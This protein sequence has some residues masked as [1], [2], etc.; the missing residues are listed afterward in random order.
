VSAE[1][2]IDAVRKRVRTIPANRRHVGVV[3]GLEIEVVEVSAV[4]DALA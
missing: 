2:A 3:D 4:E 1:T